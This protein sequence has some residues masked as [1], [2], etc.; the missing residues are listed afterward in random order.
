MPF[1]GSANPIMSRLSLGWV[2]VANLL[3][4]V[5]HLMGKQLSLLRIPNQAK[6]CF[7]PNLS[8]RSLTSLTMPDEAGMSTELA[9]PSLWG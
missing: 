7:P 1:Q 9:T 2:C 6:A 4:I 8:A 5:H 3:Q